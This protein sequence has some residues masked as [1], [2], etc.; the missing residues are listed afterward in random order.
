[1]YADPPL[2]DKPS[3]HVGYFA[4]TFAEDPEHL[5]KE[6]ARVVVVRVK[7]GGDAQVVR[8]LLVTELAVKAEPER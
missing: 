7:T 4:L 2:L 3:R 8:R 6:L 5:E 1:L